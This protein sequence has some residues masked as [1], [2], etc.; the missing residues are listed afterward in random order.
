[1]PAE[2][3]P[4]DNSDVLEKLD[5]LMRK[6]HQ[7]APP[8][9]KAVVPAPAKLSPTLP[10]PTPPAPAPALDDGIPTLTDIVEE[11]AFPPKHHELAAYPDD[12]IRSLEERLHRELENRIV[13][14][15]SLAFQQ[16]LDK[17]VEDAKREIST[18]V[19]EHLGNEAP[20]RHDPDH[21]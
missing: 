18:T 11:P 2:L 19:R 9:L 7:P 13:P 21:R 6:H 4:D 3:P 8:P 1:M 12:T 10:P 17:L 16:A 15:L 14:Q 20:P 5:A